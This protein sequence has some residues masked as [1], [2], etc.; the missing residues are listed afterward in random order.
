MAE[1]EAKGFSPT[2]VMKS[3]D[4]L[5][6]YRRGFVWAGDETRSGVSHLCA[7]S[8]PRAKE[9]MASRPEL[10]TRFQIG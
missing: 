3:E 6:L 7:R 8:R 10:M 1:L 9:L 5:E 2:L 4:T